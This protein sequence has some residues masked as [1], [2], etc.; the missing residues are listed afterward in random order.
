MSFPVREVFP[1]LDSKRIIHYLVTYSGPGFTIMCLLTN[2]S[3]NRTKMDESLEVL[4]A[5]SMPAIKNNVSLALA[6]L[7]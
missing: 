1:K 7:V 6:S 3:Q 4:S 2:D 5:F